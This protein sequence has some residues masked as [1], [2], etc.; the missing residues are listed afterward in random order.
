MCLETDI[1]PTTN[2]F[3]MQCVVGGE[4]KKRYF[5][6]QCRERGNKDRQRDRQRDSERVRERDWINH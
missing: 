6:I 5:L 3:F 4:E 2:Q 1:N